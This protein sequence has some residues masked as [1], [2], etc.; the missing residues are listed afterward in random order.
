MTS[1]P[2]HSKLIGDPSANL[3]LLCTAFTKLVPVVINFGLVRAFNLERDGLVEL[4]VWAAV[5][6]DEWVAF[7]MESNG[8]NGAS[9]MFM[10]ILAATIVE[11]GLGD[12]RIGEDGGVVLGSFL[13]LPVEPE[14]GGDLGE[15]HSDTEE[16]LK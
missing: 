5:K 13:G 12:S 4:E 8:E 16:V 3:L 15:G 6:T 2:A 1:L 14:T 9:L 11:L 7:E 10:D